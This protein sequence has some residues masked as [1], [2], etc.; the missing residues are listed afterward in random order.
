[1]KIFRD[2]LS[3]DELVTDAFS[4]KETFNGTVLEVEAKYITL[5]AENDFNIGGNPGGE[6]GQEELD[7]TARQVI[8][9]VESG[10]LVETSYDK[11][12]YM[13]HIKEYMKN[14]KAKLE[15]V[16]PERVA[17]FQKGAAEVVK[18]FL[19]NFDDYTFYT[20]ESMAPEAMV[21]LCKFSEDGMSQ[22]FYFWRDGL[23]E[24]KV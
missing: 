7:N 15:T 11:K 22:V 3:G 20:G 10:R 14:V 17:E 21:I 4:V 13:T 23:K 18:H 5:N 12:A 19:G 1:M 8:N 24:E 16:K 2:L 6:E 9:V